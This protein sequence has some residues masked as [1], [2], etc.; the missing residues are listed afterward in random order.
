MSDLLMLQRLAE[1]A[2]PPR[3]RSG[4]SEKVARSGA[5][6]VYFQHLYTR[7]NGVANCGARV[8]TPARRD[9]AAE[10]FA[11]SVTFCDIA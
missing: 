6:W 3:N 11:E 9:W 8:S 2:V 4:R 10:V 5:S 1:R 7:V